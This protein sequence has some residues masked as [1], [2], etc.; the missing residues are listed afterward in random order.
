MILI[1]LEFRV[2][3]LES[4]NGDLVPKLICS[5]VGELEA[6]LEPLRFFIGGHDPPLLLRDLDFLLLPSPFCLLNCQTGSQQLVR[7]G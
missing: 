2:P 1:D 5:L 7:V 4:T 6:A 3:H